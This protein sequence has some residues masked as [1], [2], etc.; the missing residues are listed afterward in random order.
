MATKPERSRSSTDAL[1]QFE[2]THGRLN[3]FVLDVATSLRAVG[4][5]AAPETWQGIA[6]RLEILRDALLLHFANE[7]EALFPF[8]RAS[9]PSMTGPVERLEAAHD[10][11][12]GAVVRA[13]AAATA[14]HLPLLRVLHE[15]FEKSYTEHSRAEAELFE[16]LGKTLDGRQRSELS[17][18][19]QGL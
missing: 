5:E 18:L 13:H 1:G 6:T 15:R 2:H 3:V 10:T 4:T 17:R 19:L 7:E 11:I 12:C 9:V 16:A 14:Q 8:L